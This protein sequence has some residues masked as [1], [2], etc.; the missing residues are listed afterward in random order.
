MKYLGHLSHKDPL[1]GYLRHD[2]LSQLGVNG[3][4]SDFR[5]YSIPASSHVAHS[6]GLP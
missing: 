3:V 6:D 5:V 1:Y 2:I 4:L